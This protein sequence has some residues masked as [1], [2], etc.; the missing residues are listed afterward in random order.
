MKDVT[1][2][3]EEN[4][5]QDDSSDEVDTSLNP[6]VQRQLVC[7]MQGQQ[8]HCQKENA[9]TGFLHEITTLVIVLAAVGVLALV[10]FVYLVVRK[11]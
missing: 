9:Q 3:E 1:T 11:K 10:I 7:L 5:E 4:Q 6:V 8:N 2:V